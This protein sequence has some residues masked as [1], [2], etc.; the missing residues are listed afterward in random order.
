[1]MPVRANIMG[2]LWAQGSFQSRCEMEIELDRR[3]DE[4]HSEY[5]ELNRLTY[6]FMDDEFI[7]MRDDGNY[8]S[9]ARGRSA[10]MFAKMLKRYYGEE[11]DNSIISMFHS[12]ITVMWTAFETL[13]T[14]L[15]IAVL[16]EKAE[17]GFFALN[18]DA[19]DGAAQKKF[20]LSLWKL[21]ELN[22]DVKYHMGTILKNKWDFARRTEVIKAYT[23]AF[24]DIKHDLHLLFNEDKLRWL[25]AM[26]NA[27]VH[28]GGRA[29]SEFIKL[30]SKHPV[31]S[32]IKEH[33][34]IRIDGE[35]ASEYITYTVD[36]GNRLIDLLRNLLVKENAKQP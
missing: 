30:V 1:M 27:I 18:A 11:Y 35:I 33:E 12:V 34:T 23:S 19:E 31:L 9:E 17:Y 3:I 21:R 8:S 25:N 26:R 20:E 4:T 28:A 16:N 14:D 22:Y 36:I 6:K 24:R 2:Q 15:W 7:R 5:V 29:D 13:A 10:F 32:G